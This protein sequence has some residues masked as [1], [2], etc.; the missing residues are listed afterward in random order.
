LNLV[1]TEYTFHCRQACSRAA[2]INV[3]SDEEN[4][5]NVDDIN[6]YISRL[7]MEDIQLLHNPATAPMAYHETMK[8]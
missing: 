5:E 8:S 2:V 1:E 7:Q 6:P 3:P 4:S